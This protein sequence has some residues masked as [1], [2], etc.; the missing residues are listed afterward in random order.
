MDYY[1]SAQSGTQIND[2]L[3]TATALD[4]IQAAVTLASDGDTIYIS[5]GEYLL[6]TAVIIDVD[7]L[8]IIGD[9]YCRTFVADTPTGHVKVHDILSD[10]TSNFTVEAILKI[11][12]TNVKIKNM[13]CTSFINW[14]I[15]TEND[16]LI[17]P[18][19]TNC[20]LMGGSCAS[21]CTLIE[22][23]VIGN[24]GMFNSEAIAC[25]IIASGSCVIDSIVHN[26][27]LIGDTAIENSIAYGCTVLGSGKAIN[28][29]NDSEHKVV[30]NSLFIGCADMSG[31]MQN[32]H[33]IACDSIYPE[34]DS[35][36]VYH[37]NTIMNVPDYSSYAKFIDIDT[38][39]FTR[40]RQDPLLTHLSGV[41]QPEQNTIGLDGSPINNGATPIGS[42][43]QSDIQLYT[44]DY[45][46]TSPSIKM[47]VS[48][49]KTFYVFLEKGVEYTIGVFMKKIGMAQSGPTMTIVT[50]DYE[51]VTA[52]NMAASDTWEYHE[53]TIE[54][55]ENMNC[56]IIFS[57]QPRPILVENSALSIGTV[58]QLV[59]V[60]SSGSYEL[61]TAG[62]ELRDFTTTFE[63]GEDALSFLYSNTN[64]YLSGG[65]YTGSGGTGPQAVTPPSGIHFMYYEASGKYS[66]SFEVE[67]SDM[68]LI[69]LWY[70]TYGDHITSFI[71]EAGDGETWTTIWTWD[72]VSEDLW[73]QITDLAVPA[74]SILFRCSITN[75]GYRADVCIDDLTITNLV[76]PYTYTSGVWTSASYDL[77]EYTDYTAVEIECTEVVEIGTNSI[78]YV[79]QLDGGSWIS[80]VPGVPIDLSVATTS[81]QFKA[82]LTTTDTSM[83]PILEAIKLTFTGQTVESYIS[84][85]V[86]TPTV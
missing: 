9:P 60:T 34:T 25:T 6:D 45:V 29:Y 64:F 37:S 30:C 40:L 20:F 68:S 11:S 48:A 63:D 32:C 83:S 3:T 1:V 4:T 28:N 78:N 50:D 10:G 16:P 57:A 13:E 71:F 82:T 5:S 59:D 36:N 53:R 19:L 2:G 14:V 15:T 18:E 77:T 51:V 65:N 58:Y 38:E 24:Y 56:R 55:P 22:C 44:S 49:G 41:Y 72:G 31:I 86:I 27:M 21:A 80:F 81:L 8:N 73:K 74:G 42:I 43:R 75:S 79:Y 76:L 69:S 46:N 47:D 85:L 35:V 17:L 61:A 62:L 67:I 26:S 70:H 39:F 84:D 33:V 7:N 66:A 23:T 52:T 12:A 54:V